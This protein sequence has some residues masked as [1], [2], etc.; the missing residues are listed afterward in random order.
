MGQELTDL[1]CPKPNGC[2]HSPPQKKRGGGSTAEETPLVGAPWGRERL[3]QCSIGAKSIIFTL[4]RRFCRLKCRCPFCVI[5]PFFADRLYPSRPWRHPRPLRTETRKSVDHARRTMSLYLG[6]V[7][8]LWEMKG[9][10]SFFLHRNCLPPP[11]K[12]VYRG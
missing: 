10:S 6:T 3:R 11:P 5:V 8:K 4:S 12:R 1:S 7:K 2:R 9:R